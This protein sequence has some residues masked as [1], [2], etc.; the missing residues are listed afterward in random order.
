M[1]ASTIRHIHACTVGDFIIVEVDS[2]YEHPEDKTR[3]PNIRQASTIRHIHACIV[4]G[5]IIVEID[6][7]Y[8]HPED[9]RQVTEHQAG[10]HHLAHARLHSRRLYYSGGRL[11][12]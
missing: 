7:L 2:L 11:P 1:Q 12:L 6:S 8:E 4:G 9:W 5:F 3:Y 10:Q